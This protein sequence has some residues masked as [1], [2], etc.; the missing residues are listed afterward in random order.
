MSFVAFNILVFVSVV[1]VACYSHFYNGN[2]INERTT[3]AAAIFSQVMKDYANTHI[4]TTTTTAIEQQ[5]LSKIM[6]S[7]FIYIA[8]T[9]LFCISL[10]YL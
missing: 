5:Q 7:D 8:S 6:P 1:A 2:I 3:I 10:H 9:Y 4:A